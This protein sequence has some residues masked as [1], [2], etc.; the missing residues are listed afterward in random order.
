MRIVYEDEIIQLP[1]KVF[2]WIADPEKAMKW[3]KNVKSG[4]IIK[5]DQGIIGT[6]F[7]EVIEE[8]GNTLEMRGTIS[9]YKKDQIIGFHIESKIH[10]FDVSYILEGKGNKTKFTIEAIIHWK[11]PMN[12]IS[13]FIREKIVEKLKKQLELEVKDLKSF[14]SDS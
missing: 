7:K 4:E 8:D 9:K 6:V 12:V 2:P 5:N 1:E 13:I 3:Q 11:F 14:C 10:I